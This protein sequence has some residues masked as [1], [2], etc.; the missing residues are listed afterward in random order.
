MRKVVIG[1]LTTSV[2][3]V[4][5]GLRVIDLQRSRADTTQ[6]AEARA[7]NLAHILSEYV[8]EAF[9]S[10]DA[11]LRQLALHSRRIGGPSA[12]DR[13]WAP[14]LAS[15]RVGLSGIG[16]VSVADVDGI[17]RH[18]TR[19]DLVGQS[20]R[21]E[22]IFQQSL[23]VPGDGLIV[24][25][26][27]ASVNPPRG[28]VI[29]IG[30]RLT[31]VDG[32]VDGAVVAS[33]IPADLRRFFGSV[34]VGPR[35][36]LWVFHRDGVIL[37]REPS[38]ANPIGESA[39]ENPL[40]LAASQN[41]AGA[42]HGAVTPGGP[43]MLSAFHAR[44]DQPLIVAVSL[45]R[46]EVLA[47]WR[48]EVNG[49]AIAFGVAAV[50]LVAT[51]LVLY[52]QMDQKAAAEGAL[53]QARRRE[54]ERLLET[55]QQL[56][57]TLDREQMARREAETANALK[58]Q[59]VMAVS[60]EL[61]TPLTAIAGWS[62]LLVDGLV[63]DSKKD[64]A[65]RTIER[66]ARAQTRLIDDLLDVSGTMSGRMRLDVRIVHI[67]EVVKNALEAVAPAIDA[68]A[69]QLETSLDGAAGSISGDPER[70]QQV[71]F[72][73]LSNA[74]KFTPDGGKVRVSLARIGD[75]VEIV[76]SDTGAGI[77]PDF[78]PHV[79]ERFRQQQ[80]GTSRRHG[81]LG[82]G[83]AIV[84]NLVELHGGSVTADSQG[85]GRGATFTVRLPAMKRGDS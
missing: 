12:D 1:A 84:R 6:A 61:R 57:A 70:L 71:V 64:A 20:R 34:G 58:D 78:L 72:N 19:P 76:V 43:V 80:A 14:S 8:G 48:R 5:G 22:Y 7:A 53:E 62:R 82:L 36:V 21:D 2:L 49:S 15:A 73:L 11:A 47:A 39:S 75:E 9:A 83:L 35:G 16:S 74:V 37:F 44:S 60:H 42:F 79:F 30:R 59:F 67:E 10:A 68:K 32:A 33:F 4:M 41:S 24:G 45:D 51:L 46:D 27:F 69:I 50:L 65:L 55:N 54:A 25:T 85:D 28:F 40:F 18:S 77:S 23:R 17:I 52:R 13:D 31:R 3:L 81:G 66:N 29:P 63:D 26:P 38:S 56:A